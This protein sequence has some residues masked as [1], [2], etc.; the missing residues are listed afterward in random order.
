MTS[1]ITVK[2]TPYYRHGIAVNKPQVI[3]RSKTVTSHYQIQVFKSNYLFTLLSHYFIQEYRVCFEIKPNSPKVWGS[4]H[5][6]QHLPCGIRGFKHSASGHSCRRHITLPLTQEQTLHLLLRGEKSSP[7]LCL[8]PWSRQ[9]IGLWRKNRYDAVT[10]GRLGTTENGC[11][12]AK[13]VNVSA[14][15]CVVWYRV[16]TVYYQDKTLHKV[17]SNRF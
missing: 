1:G 10:I 17:Y 3:L 12:W 2:T 4:V 15:R 14:F 13:L 8:M 9:K 5:T 16:P 6:G 7:S 11:F